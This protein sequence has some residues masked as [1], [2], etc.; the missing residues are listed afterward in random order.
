MTVFANRRQIE[1]VNRRLGEALRQSHEAI[2]VSEVDLHF[3]YI[4]PAFTRL[5]GYQLEEVVGQSVRLLE[6]AGDETASPDEA[7][8]MAGKSGVFHGEVLRRAKDGRGIPV[9]IN[10]APVLDEH[11]IITGYVATMTDLTEIKRVTEQLRENEEKFHIIFDQTFEFMSVLKPDGVLINTNQISLNALGIQLPDVVGL[12][13]WEAPWWTSSCEQQENLKQAIAQAAK[14]EFVRFEVTIAGHETPLR[15]IDLSLK[16]VHGSH[17]QIEQLIVE[18]HDITERRRAEEEVRQ[19]NTELR[20]SNRKLEQAQIQLLQSEKMASVGL[21]AAGVAHEINNPIGFVSSNLGALEKYAKELLELLAA[22]E[23]LEALIAPD[24]PNQTTSGAPLLTQLRTIKERIDLPFLRED[25]INL[26]TESHEGITRVKNIVLSLKDFARAGHAEHWEFSD[27]H[28]GI[29]STLKVVWNELKYK[30]EVVKEYGE[31]P[32]IR[33]LL[34]QL[35]QVFMNLLINAAQAIEVKGVITIR[36]GTRNNEVW[37]EIIDTGKGIAAEHLK[38]IFDPFFTTKP[39]G[40]GTGLGLS[41]SY[42]I[43]QKH[44]GRI[45]VDSEPGKGSTFRVCLPI[46]QTPVEDA[47]D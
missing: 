30:C 10:I 19:I 28:T 15:Y 36:T 1:L 18:G 3:S 8:H 25:L 6:V 9:L 32:K 11:C 14:G 44:Q 40:K 21:L 31:L 22:Y 12:P 7:T 13:F 27:L 38:S 35:N 34:P 43:V 41:V 42:S 23:S 37:V 24:Q 20:A 2:A 39:I 5:F 17:G 16:P 4:N 45:E 26:L 29:E 46:K 47:S 33:C